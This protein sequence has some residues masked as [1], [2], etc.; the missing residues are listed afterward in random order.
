MPI[1]GTEFRYSFHADMEF[2][3]VLQFESVCNTL[4]SMLDDFKILGVYQKGLIRKT[5]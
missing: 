5:V 4:K 3:T 2:D 1:P